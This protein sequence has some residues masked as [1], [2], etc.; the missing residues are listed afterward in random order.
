MARDVA[1]QVLED[2]IQE[3]G[4]HAN[5]RQVVQGDDALVDQAFGQQAGAKDAG[6]QAASDGRGEQPAIQADDQVGD[7]RLGELAA[8]VPQ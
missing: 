4:V 6:Q 8:V 1:D 7:G 3:D 2:S 5:R